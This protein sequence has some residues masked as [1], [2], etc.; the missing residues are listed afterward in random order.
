MKSLDIVRLGL[1][2][3]LVYV[4]MYGVPQ[5]RVLLQP[6]TG[7]LKNVNDAALQMAANDR[8]GLA[9]AL[10]AS[11]QM[12]ASDKAGLIKTT[13]DLQRFVRGTVAYGYTSFT[14]NKYP[15][16]SA[17]IQKEL[18]KSVGPTV[19]TVTNQ[20]RDQTVES[21]VELSKAVR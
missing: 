18:E 15:T 8:L 2:G 3:V 10:L 17:E 7:P 11:S 9:E 12:L 6:Y 14:L 1:A 13:E 19:Q 4:A 20:L 21:L 5:N 16:V